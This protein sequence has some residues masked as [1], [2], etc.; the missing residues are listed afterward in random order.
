M[1]KDEMEQAMDGVFYNKSILRSRGYATHPKSDKIIGI[2]KFGKHLLTCENSNNF[3]EVADKDYQILGII[4][5][6]KKWKKFVWE[7]CQRVIMDKDC[8]ED[9][10]KLIDK[11]TEEKKN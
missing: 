10:N 3:L 8:L 7:Q 1:V 2:Y 5:Y 11:K 9:I 6:Y 4:F